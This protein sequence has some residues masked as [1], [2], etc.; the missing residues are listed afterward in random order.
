MSGSVSNWGS[1]SDSSYVE[2]GQSFKRKSEDHT[3]ELE[4]RLQRKAKKVALAKIEEQK[5]PKRKPGDIQELELKFH[6]ENK[7][8]SYFTSFE[9]A[10]RA[11]H[12]QRGWDFDGEDADDEYE[13]DVI[14]L[15]WVKKETELDGPDSPSGPGDSEP[16]SDITLEELGRKYKDLTEAAREG[17]FND[18]IGRAAEV[19][20]IQQALL[21][22]YEPGNIEIVGEHGIGKKTLVHLLA[23]DLVHGKKPEGLKE[24]HLVMIDF[25]EVLKKGIGWYDNFKCYLDECASLKGRVIAVIPEF[26]KILSKRKDYGAAVRHLSRRVNEGLQIILTSTKAVGSHSLPNLKRRFTKLEVKEYSLSDLKLRLMKR[27]VAAEHLLSTTVSEAAVVKAFEISQ[28]EKGGGHASRKEVYER[29]CEI[30]DLAVAEARM[31][32]EEMSDEEKKESG[33]LFPYADEEI[34]KFVSSSID[35]EQAVITSNSD[36]I[37]LRLDLGEDV[38]NFVGRLK[39]HVMGQDHALLAVA[40]ALFVRSV[41]LGGDSAKGPIG[42]FFFAGTTGVGKTETVKALSRE[43]GLPCKHFDMSTFTQEHDVKRLLGAPPS[44]VGYGDGGELTNW[45]EEHPKSILLFD[46]AEKAHIDILKA[47][48]GLMDEGKITDSQAQTYSGQGTI[49]V[50]TSN[51]CS[52]VIGELYAAGYTPEQVMEQV[53]PMMRDSGLPPEWLNRLTASLA[54]RPITEEVSKK[55]IP[56]KLKKFADGVLERQRIELVWNEEVID[57]LQKHGYSAEFGLRPLERL[58][59]KSAVAHAL[60]EKIYQKEVKR[61]DKAEIYVEED[62]IRVRKVEK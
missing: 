37:E 40:K 59:N 27:Y 4:Q 56:M 11:S 13:Q 9:E 25:E 29:A 12:G 36:E 55:L 61:G 16:P 2:D 43:T 49:I 17:A 47:L 42:V 45:L 39:N 41:D 46:E 3:G 19:R 62:K 38:N 50:L 28:L 48:L 15:P 60:V 31:S 57:W 34:V 24:R 30:L 58:I 7:R 35:G 20:R 32:F 5:N 52:K 6:R 1:D 51:L 14:Q 18:L 23:K 26:Q 8:K 33:V 53:L 44:Y 21:G 10:T 22:A 54:F